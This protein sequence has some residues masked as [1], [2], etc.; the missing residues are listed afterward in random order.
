MGGSGGSS[1]TATSGAGGGCN[2]NQTIDYEC[3]CTCAGKQVIYGGE[4]CGPDRN[5]EPCDG[6]GGSGGAGG[7]PV[8]ED[9]ANH[10]YC[11]A[12]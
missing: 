9:C 10:V 5:G 12:L 4:W 6:A 3:V 11:D 8:N 2:D 1:S 7:H